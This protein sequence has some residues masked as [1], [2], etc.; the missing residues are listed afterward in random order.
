MHRNQD[1]PID[2]DQWDAKIYDVE[3]MKYDY[4]NGNFNPDDAENYNH[5][6][7]IR[8]SFVNGQFSQ[9]QELCAEHGFNYA[10]E[11]EKFRRTE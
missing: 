10:V 11:R 9:A 4:T 8:D 7:M 1:P 3:A 2:F 6:N 5:A